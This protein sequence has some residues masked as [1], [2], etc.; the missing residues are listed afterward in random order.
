[1]N[2]KG[3][4]IEKNK[5]FNKNAKKKERQ[6]P[7]VFMIVTVFVFTLLMI[8]FVSFAVFKPNIDKPLPFEDGTSG[9]P[10]ITNTPVSDIPTV[11]PGEGE[12]IRKD[13][14]YTFLVCGTDKIS[15]NTDVMML[16][17]IDIKNKNINILQIPRDTFINPDVA[18][19]N[20]TRVNA[21]YSSAY[22]RSGG[23]GEARKKNAMEVLRTKLEASLCIAI[24]RYILMDTEAFSNIINAIGGVDYYVPFDMDYE[25]PEQGLYIHLK[26][27]MQHLDGAMAE[28]FIR[29]RSGYVTGDIGR[30]EARA[31]FLAAV[32]SQ[33]IEKFSLS[34]AVNIVKQIF[35]YVTTDMSIEDAVFFANAVYGIGNDKINIKTIGGSSV[36]N[37]KTGVWTYYAL[38]KRLALEDIN[39][40]MNAFGKDITSAIFDKKAL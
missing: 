22:N 3:G 21:I 39:K 30:V 19:Y 40:Y 38:N 18:G 35:S 27:G 32:Y 9:A 20:V 34:V 29:Y 13:G 24:D 31:D 6:K 14:Y 11:I 8:V 10:E 36:Q 5:N 16:V 12:Y 23:T 17:S 4:D 28:Q 2:G 37:P 25:D 7:I 33:T 1:M 15:K 26:E